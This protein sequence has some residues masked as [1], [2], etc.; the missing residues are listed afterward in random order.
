MDFTCNVLPQVPLMR[1]LSTTDNKP[2]QPQAADTTSGIPAPIV[3]PT[4]TTA[5]VMGGATAVGAT[6]EVKGEGVEGG[7]N[8][9]YVAISLRSITHY[10]GKRAFCL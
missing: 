1:P 4:P 6:L 2:V 5:T 8:M 7:S 9:L 3:H 10:I